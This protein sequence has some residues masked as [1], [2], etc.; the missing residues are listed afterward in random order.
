MQLIMNMLL[1]DMLHVFLDL[2]IVNIFMK[3]LL[4]T[5]ERVITELVNSEYILEDVITD[6]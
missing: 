1:L 6:Q 5:S 2:L 4:L 3:M